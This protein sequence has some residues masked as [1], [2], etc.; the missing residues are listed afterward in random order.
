MQEKMVFIT[1]LDHVVIVP[2]LGCVKGCVSLLYFVY[3]CALYRIAFVYL[4]LEICVTFDAPSDGVDRDTGG[5][6]GHGA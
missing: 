4:C 1:S 5:E 3:I 6:S 2:Y